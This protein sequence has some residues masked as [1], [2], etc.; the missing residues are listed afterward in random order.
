[1]KDII[2]KLNS[3]IKLGIQI[4]L[5][6]FT[7]GHSTAGVLPLLPLSIVKFDK[8]LLD[9]FYQNEKKAK[10][11]Y[12]NLIS[13]IKELDLKIFAEGIETS[14]ELRFLKENNV[15]Y[16]QG[17]LISKPEPYDEKTTFSLDMNIN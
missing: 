2:N 7:A 17:Y 4:S 11:V 13:L 16:G 1:M 12:L 15:D 9:S 10:I 8:S 14:E 5:D 6:D 3:L